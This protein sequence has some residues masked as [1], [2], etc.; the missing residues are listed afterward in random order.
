[1]T[2]HPMN[3]F[4]WIFADIKDAKRVY[5]KFVKYLVKGKKHQMKENLFNKENK[6]NIS[7][8]NI[9]LEISGVQLEYNSNPNK[10]NK[11]EENLFDDNKQEKFKLTID[12]NNKLVVNKNEIVL[13]YGSNASGK[14]LLIK[15]I[16]DYKINRNNEMNSLAS[17]FPDERNCITT[18]RACNWTFITQS[19]DLHVNS[20]GTTDAYASR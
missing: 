8:S 5:E 7:K 17:T 13:I 19:Q 16:V 18:P 11:S 2:I 3:V 15:S 1:M 4:P 12:D 14:S 10:I 6:E 9:V 20:C